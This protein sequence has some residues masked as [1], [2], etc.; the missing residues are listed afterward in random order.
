MPTSP[1]PITSLPTAPSRAD[2]ANFATRADAF[3]GALG[4]FGTQ[5][6]ALGS[7]TYNNAVEAATS[8]TTAGTS[9]SNAATSASNAAASATAAAG[10]ATAAA[11]SATSAAASY[12]A[13]D[14][15]YLGSKAADPSVDNDG[16]AL[17]TGALY[18]NT[19]A[20]EMRVWNGAAWVV[21]YLPAG[22]Y[23][24]LTGGT[25]SGNLGIGATSHSSKLGIAVALETA[26]AQ[27]N[28]GI[29][30]RASSGSTGRYTLIN[31]SGSGYA[32]NVAQVGGV[33]T[34]IGSA[35]SDSAGTLVFTTKNTTDSVPFERSRIT[36]G[37]N[38]LV[39]TTT[40]PGG[41]NTRLAVDH[42]GSDYGLTLNTATSA[43]PNL[44]QFRNSNSNG[45]AR[46]LNNTGG[47]L[48]FY[49]NPTTEAARI[50]SVGDFIPIVQTAAPTL[51]SNQQ[52]V[53]TLTSNTNLRISVRGTDGTTR[54]ANIT[55]A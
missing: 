6:N 11:N 19:S 16:N 48:T 47:P 8:A 14:D 41:N 9:A 50:T 45:E 39:G 28:D 53:F 26:F 49:R 51:T 22:A 30:L 38:L 44:L 2:P 32:G 25:L 15:R 29:T 7:T 17:L 12:D 21:S 31:F 42:T 46:L 13:F 33:T 34:T 27:T 36:S 10:S 23:L 43:G 24:Q 3:L 5:T 54:V 4:A 20:N 37:G 1:T 18:W 55:L 40:D 35:Y 52:M